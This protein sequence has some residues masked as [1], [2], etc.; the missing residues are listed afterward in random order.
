MELAVRILL[1]LLGAGSLFYLGTICLYCGFLPAFSWFWIGLGGGGIFCGFLLGLEKVKSLG[2]Y[3]LLCR[4]LFLF[5][6]LS[7]SF[8]FCMIISLTSYGNRKPQM[9]AD[10]LIVLGAKVKGRN[11]TKALSGRIQAAIEYLKE[12]PWTKV[13]LTGGQGKGEEISESACMEKV[14]IEAG[15]SPDRIEKEEQ[16][17]TTV[18]NILF[19]GQFIKEKNARLIVVTSDF[20]VKRGVIIARDAGYEN[21][22]GLGDK[23]V[24]IM[25][26]HYYVRES[27]AWVKY[28]MKS[29]RTI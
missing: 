1:K 16:S 28:E 6:I 19:A 11:P 15:I 26:L 17:K 13:V 25:R 12:N 5:M 29:R 10:Y 18:E 22:E 7:V 27:L 9:G 21:V 3:P 4:I 14:M 2:F 23:S 20:H 24:Q 8:L